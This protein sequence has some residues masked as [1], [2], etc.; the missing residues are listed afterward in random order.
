M[1]LSAEICLCNRSLAQH[2]MRTSGK[3]T[4]SSLA[5]GKK[6]EE[7][8]V[9]LCTAQNRAGNKYSLDGGNVE[10]VF[11]RFSSEGKA[12]IRMR[13][14]P[15]DIC[16]TKADPVALKAFLAIMAKVVQGD[17]VGRERGRERRKAES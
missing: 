12:T 17:Q 15:H 3:S 16:V 14:P 5:M 1:R 4:R 7:A 13:S 6:A 8:F 10:R 11:S 2:N 9:L